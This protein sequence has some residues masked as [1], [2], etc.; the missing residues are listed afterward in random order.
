MK[1]VNDN[2][3]LLSISHKTSIGIGHDF[4]LVHILIMRQIAHGICLGNFVFKQFY[5]INLLFKTSI[6]KTLEIY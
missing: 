1:S 3:R 6:S 5:G 4:S 2:L